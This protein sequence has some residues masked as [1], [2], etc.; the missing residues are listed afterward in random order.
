MYQKVP[1]IKLKKPKV[2]KI[3]R[4]YLKYQNVP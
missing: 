2:P 1:K 3:F 4:E